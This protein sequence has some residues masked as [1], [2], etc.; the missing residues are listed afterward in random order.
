MNV[1]LENCY[2]HAFETPICVR[3]VSCMCSVRLHNW[4][5]IVHR[6]CTAA[7]RKTSKC[8]AE[9]STFPWKGSVSAGGRT[10]ADGLTPLADTCGGSWWLVLVQKFRDAFFFAAYFNMTS[11]EGGQHHHAT[12]AIGFSVAPS[13]VDAYT[14]YL[15]IYTFKF[16]RQFVHNL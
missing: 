3:Q 12:G 4:K 8:S 14:K 10:I 15:L 7:S 1:Y 9:L 13:G 2:T 11:L 6:L 16:T 5:R